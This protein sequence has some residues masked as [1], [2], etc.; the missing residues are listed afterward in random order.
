MT[1][2]ATTCRA[3]KIGTVPNIAEGEWPKLVPDQAAAIAPLR[4]GVPDLYNHT[5]TRFVPLTE[6]KARGWTLFYIGESCRWGHV[7]PRYVSNPRMCVDCHRTRE[8]KATI[9]AKGNKEYS[10]KLKPHKQPL[11][12]GDS[13]G[14]NAVAVMPS[15]PEPDALEKK[16]LTEY[17]K[18]RDFASAAAMCGRHE[19]EFLGRLSYNHIFRAAVNQ[20]EA[21]NGLSRTL[22]LGEDFEWTDDKRATLLR[23]YVDTGDIAVARAAVQV[24]NYHFLKEL[25]FNPGFAEDY[26]EVEKLANRVVG[27][28]GVSQAI[29][30]DSRLLQRFLSNVVPERFGENSKV[31]V[32]LNVTEKLTDEQLTLRFEQAIRQL[33]GKVNGILD[34]E[35][36]VVNT[37]AEAPTARIARDENPPRQPQSNLDLV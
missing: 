16:F 37:P 2:T 7:A 32:D 1:A 11:R 20:L 29:R 26:A 14:A 6:A 30:G 34:A 24:S 12:L 25:E 27:E 17:A 35:F 22:S 18:L 15:A 28:I 19:A 31:K 4:D 13:G 5:P 10:G 3:R 36:Q 23:V 21:D 33:G 8:G 9:G